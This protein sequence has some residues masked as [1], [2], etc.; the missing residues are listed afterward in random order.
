MRIMFIRKDKRLSPESLAS[1]GTILGVQVNIDCPVPRWMSVGNHCAYRRQKIGHFLAPW[2]R[3]R[4][5]HPIRTVAGSRE[6]GTAVV[7]VP[8]N[9]R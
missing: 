4:R 8:R 7:S 6:T 3:H 2:P 5:H 9:D 1:R